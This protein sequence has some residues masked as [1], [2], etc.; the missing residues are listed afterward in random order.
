[1]I[2]NAMF[3]PKKEEKRNLE[4]WSSVDGGKKRQL[5]NI[6]I[7]EGSKNWVRNV[8]TKGQANINQMY[9][10]KILKMEINIKLNEKKTRK[11]G[12]I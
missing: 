2:M 12:N 1:M 3:T 8:K 11:E 9:Q 7:N 4:T 10:H 5:D 6:M